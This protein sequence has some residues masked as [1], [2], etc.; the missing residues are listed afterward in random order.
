MAAK[1]ITVEITLLSVNLSNTLEKPKKTNHLINS[2]IVY[3]RPSVALKSASQPCGMESGSA[4]FS[5]AGW[6]KRI[7]FKEQVEGEF[8]ITVSVTRALSDKQIEGFARYLG[9]LAFGLAADAV[10]DR[11]PVIG[12]AASTPFKYME[13]QLGKSDDYAVIATG[14]ISAD[15]ASLSDGQVLA[16]PLTAP[17]DLHVTANRVPSNGKGPSSVRKIVLRK[18]EPNGEAKLLIRIV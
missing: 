1:K 17:E 13:K 8:G 11:F 5:G 12:A 6:C 18:G 9:S 16:V 14:S 4:D 3:P 10:E 15:P 7:L 2:S